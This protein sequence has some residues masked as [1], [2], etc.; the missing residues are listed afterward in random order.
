MDTHEATAEASSFVSGVIAIGSP[1]S[2]GS[3]YAVHW[4]KERAYME[5]FNLCGKMT[6]EVELSCISVHESFMLS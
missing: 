4:I 5:I 1:C 6:K 2:V 3:S